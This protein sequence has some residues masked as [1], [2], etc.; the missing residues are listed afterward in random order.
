LLLWQTSTRVYQTCQ[1]IEKILLSM[2]E[3]PSMPLF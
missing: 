1:C 2:L 3:T